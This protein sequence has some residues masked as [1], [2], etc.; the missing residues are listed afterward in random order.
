MLIFYPRKQACN[1]QRQL[2][3]SYRRDSVNGDNISVH[4]AKFRDIGFVEKKALPVT[5]SSVP[6]DRHALGRI[7]G[8]EDRIIVDIV[9]MALGARCEFS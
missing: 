1:S 9:A 5:W 4:Q 3:T 8:G 7:L 6:L 2:S